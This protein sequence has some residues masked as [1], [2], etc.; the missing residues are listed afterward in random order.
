MLGTDL[1]EFS[2]RSGDQ[3]AAGKM[4]GLAEQAAGTL[5]HRGDGLLGKGR[6]FQTGNS[7]IMIEVVKHALPIDCR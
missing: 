2:C 7:Q 6:V 1:L 5:M 3:G 4:V